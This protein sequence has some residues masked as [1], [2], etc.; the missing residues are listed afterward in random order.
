MEETKE[1]LRMQFEI[2]TNIPTDP[3][4]HNWQQYAMWLEKLRIQEINNKLVKENLLLRNK[5]NEAINVLE[6][7]MTSGDE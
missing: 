4:P 3:Y 1:K 7:A 5:I 2:E 6:G